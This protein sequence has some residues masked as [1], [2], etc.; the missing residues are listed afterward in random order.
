MEVLGE[1]AGTEAPHHNRRERAVLAA[2]LVQRPAAVSPDVIAEAVWGS[3]PPATWAKQIQAAIWRLRSALGNAA[4]QTVGRAYRLELPRGAV[5]VDVFEDEVARAAA[6]SHDGEHARAAIALERALGLWNCVEPY[7]TVADWPPATVEIERLCAMRLQAEDDLLAERLAAGDHRGVASAAAALASAE[8]LR[9]SRWLSLATALYRCERQADALAALRRARAVLMDELGLD[10][11]PA[12][13][14]LEGA[15]LRHDPELSVAPPVVAPDDSC[16][17]KGLS[18]YEPGDAEVY[19]GRDADIARAISTLDRMRF[20]VLA[21]ASGT[22]KSS[23]LRAGVQPA[24]AAR[25]TVI[26]EASAAS[27]SAETIERSPAHATIA[28]DQFETVFSPA[29]REDNARAV[30]EALAAHHRRGGG[31]AIALRSDHLDACAADPAIGPLVLSSLHLVTPLRGAGLRAAIEEPARHAHLTLEHGFA[32]VVLADAEAAAGALPLLSHA[33]AETWHRRE[34]STLTIDGYTASGGLRGAVA[35]S[36][37]L[38]FTNLTVEDRRRCAMILR[39]LVTLTETGA[40]VAHPVDVRTLTDPDLERVVS[41]LVQARLLGSREHHL[42]LAHESL[43]HAW[44]R[45]QGWLESDMEGQRVLGH[46]STAAATWDALGRLDSDLYRGPRL[47]LAWDWAAGAEGSLTPLESD[48][49]AASR[50]AE[51]AARA[52]ADEAERRESRA[53]RRVR[54]MRWWAAAAAV[55]ALVGL[56]AATIAYKFAE[57]SGHTADQQTEK[58][59]LE[60]LTKDFASAMDHSRTIGLLLA[61]EAYQRWPKDPATQGAL[62]TA[63]A[64]EPSFLGDLNYAKSLD[65][66]QAPN[67]ALVGDD[68]HAILATSDWLLVTDLDSHEV[69]HRIP[70]TVEWPPGAA[71]EVAVSSDGT[72]AVLVGWSQLAQSS[73]PWKLVLATYDL[74]R[75]AELTVR[76]I[77]GN[78]DS[79]SGVAVSTRGTYVAVTDDRS[80]T[81]TLR[82]VATGRVTAAVNVA[83]PQSPATRSPGRAA[84]LD[85]ATALIT[86]AKGDVLMVE[87][88]SGKVRRTYAS[89][90]LRS[91]TAIALVDDD[92][93]IAA[94]DEG[95]VAIDL[96][97]GRVRWT[98]LHEV[99]DPGACQAVAVAEERGVLYC[100]SASGTI[101]GYSLSTGDPTDTVRTTQHGAVSALALSDDDT[102]LTAFAADHAVLSRWSLDGTGPITEVV[103]PGRQAVDR[104]GAQ[105]TQL[106]TVSR[107][108]VANA[109]GDFRAYR[110]WDVA[111][112]SPTRAAPA[113]LTDMTWFGDGQV[114]G[115]SPTTGE[116]DVYDAASGRLLAAD[117]VPR[118]ASSLAVSPDWSR[119][120]AMFDDHTLRTYDTRTFRQIGPT[121]HTLGVPSHVSASAGGALIAVSE[122]LEYAWITQFLDGDTG[123]T[124]GNPATEV[125]DTVLAPDGSGIGIHSDNQYV[126]RFDQSNP[127]I[128]RA[129]SAASPIDAVELNA[130]G[131]RLLISTL[132]GKVSLHDAKTGE[133]IGAPLSANAPGTVAGLLRPDGL[134]IALNVEQGIAVWNLDPEAMKDAACAA[135]GRNL[136]K[137]EWTRYLGEIGEW[138]ATCPGYPTLS[139]W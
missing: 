58:A 98:R 113:A 35:R 99:M 1:T 138:H 53:R 78:D 60:A 131:T 33:L 13:V 80:G 12:L 17:Y 139:D 40:V 129:L 97:S 125:R 66:D 22:G 61:V 118:R 64:A 75:G 59:Q 44:P 7:A 107:D 70:T 72:R 43:V 82:E 3:G 14:R 23:L 62:L 134:A 2:L 76:V 50:E 135:A 63:F 29:L 15:I 48:F 103:A 96:R 68:R 54:T 51:A 93:V 127:Q 42:E 87:A 34:G 45:L 65:V 105:G 11:S 24:L 56:A 32:D 123:A 37:E 31:I 137:S 117:A 20:L 69:E 83:R 57:S 67:V 128:W 119:A 77:G 26:V 79:S 115:R 109:A 28:I 106:I 73:A 133:R 21:G 88:A 112:A 92:T 47:A 4:I 36:A 46:L 91:N 95:L 30:C 120:Y 85:D 74:G 94:G 90:A 89:P 126:R 84:F 27:V 49:L 124:I 18:A 101:R 122:D 16:P 114:I 71:P 8:P 110:V 38:L 5:D 52:A 41:R 39:R 116:F 136:T 111:S 104:W 100:G 108:P 10:P 132:D 102:T 9:E 55:T 121:V 6:L 25:G 130:D 19:F 81:I 86:S